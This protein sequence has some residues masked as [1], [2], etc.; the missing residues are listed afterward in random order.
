MN[1]YNGLKNLYY[2]LYQPDW[3][4]NFD[5][6][7]I[8]KIFFDFDEED[9][10]EDVKKLHQYLLSED[11]QHTMLFSGKKGFHVY[12]FV[13]ATTLKVN[14]KVALTNTHDFFCSKLSI[15]MDQHIRGDIARIARVPNTYHMT[16][17]KF[18]IPVTE[19]DLANGIEHIHKK[20]QEQVFV[21]QIY[22]TKKYDL[23]EMSFIPKEQPM[24]EVKEYDYDI[25][26][27][28][29]M[30]EQFLPC[31]KM[32]L[33]SPKQY[34][35][36]RT[37]YYFSVYCRDMGLPPKMCEDLAKKFWSKTLDSSGMKTKFREF[38]EERQISYGYSGKKDYFPN[39]E[40]LMQDGFCKGACEKFKKNGSP[41]YR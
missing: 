9:A 1:Q 4:D 20:A 18:C 26:V 31:V 34:C 15:K 19:E 7:D 30:V 37:R 36:N 16:G 28:D 23:S 5:N 10:I 27:D 3:Q 2:S 38:K 14:N 6:A 35:K 40:K 24:I 29:E 39:C 33:T 11:I 32:W 41:L 8:D 13:D 17:K 25:H 12:V 21:Y 22:G